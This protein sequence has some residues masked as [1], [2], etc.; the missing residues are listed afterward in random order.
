[1]NITNTIAGIATL[2]LAAI[3]MFA[4]GTAAHAAQP[5]TVQVSD[6]NL[7]TPEGASELDR[8]ISA[9]ATRFCRNEAPATGTRLSA[10]CKAAVRA[11]VT[12]KMAARTTATQYAAR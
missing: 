2:A 4:L 6:I 8:R 10:S 11:E 5:V 3:P 1:M 7:S 12:E 9:A